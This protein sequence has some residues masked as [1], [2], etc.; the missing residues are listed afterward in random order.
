VKKFFLVVV[1]VVAL[2][3]ALRYVRH[4]PQKKPAPPGPP[5]VVET[6]EPAEKVPVPK[7]DEQ[8][9]PPPA[10]PEPPPPPRIA[11]SVQI[12]DAE[13]QWFATAP[14]LVYY[15]VEGAMYAQKKVADEAPESVGACGSAFDMIA[16]AQ[17]VVFCDGNGLIERITAGTN[18]SHLIADKGDDGC[19]M[20]AIDGKYAYFV[21]PGYEDTK[22]PG[23]FRVLRSGG[24]PEKIHATRP[25]EQFMLDVGDDALWI[26]AWGAGTISKLAKTPGSKARTL[27]TG[28]KGIVSLAE[29]KTS[30][31][32]YA[33]GTG[34]V[35]RRKKTGGPIEVIGHDV[36]QE[37]IVVTADGHA[38]WFE[39]KAGDDKRLVHLAPGATKTETLAS[40]LKTPAMRADTEGVYVSELDKSGIFMFKR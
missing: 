36:D 22:D 29:D 7:P 4:K 34:E 25:K 37:P 23:V 27:I 10:A 32:W 40:G 3:L 19:I 20:M 5:V 15:C 35:R 17:G 12:S 21:V 18:G 39:G 31:Y 33:E 14:G 11:G 26:G 30:L 8:P 9:L 6:E 13:V 38:Y 2:G 28:Q 1:G 16:D 24:T